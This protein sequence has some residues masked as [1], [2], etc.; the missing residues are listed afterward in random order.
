M[1]VTGFLHSVKT[2]ALHVEDESCRQR[3]VFLNETGLKYRCFR[4][5]LILSSLLFGLNMHVCMFVSRNLPP[6]GV[7][8]RR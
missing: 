8:R 1:V 6:D 4:I 3:Y 5:K 7:L 2:N